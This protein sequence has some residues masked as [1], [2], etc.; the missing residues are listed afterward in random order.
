MGLLDTFLGNADQTQA[1]SLLGA[2]MMAG[3]TPQGLLA[4]S[5][6]M[7][8]AKDRATDREMKQMQMEEARMKMEQLRRAAA[9]EQGLSA[10]MPQFMN[11][12]RPAMGGTADVNAALPPEMQIGAQRP[13]PAQRPGFDIQGYTNAA[14]QQRLMN[15]LQA[16]EMQNKFA[17]ASQVN[18]LDVKD[19][20]PRSVAEFQRTG[21]Y[22]VLK[23]MDKLHFADTGGAIN[24]INPFTGVPVNSVP[25]TGNPFSD[26]LV[27]DGA[28]GFRPN[29]PLIGAKSQIARAGA[30]NM[31]MVN[32]QEGEESKAVG[33]FFGENYADV[34]KSG[35]N[36][37]SSMNRLD[38]LGQLLDGVD[39]GK[40]A[41]L[42]VEVSKAA[43][44]FGL[45]IDPKLAN[46]EAAVALSSEIALQLRNPSGGAGM[47]GAMSDA[48]RN[49]LNGMV[50]GIE[51]TPEGRKTIL[52][53]AKKM[54]QRDV[55]VAR[56]AREY[57][58]KR[59]T[60]NEGFYEELARFSE[61]NPLF[62]GGRSSG[63]GAN[64]DALVNKYAR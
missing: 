41:P 22:S 15:P 42:G 34:Q 46:K 55:Q 40:F 59:G 5:Q 57:R 16:L 23:R 33:K 19:F 35:F 6:Y 61:A 29:S 8:G 18:K 3:N 20:D 37:Q 7:G 28:G 62:A 49:F 17:P 32:K 50:P 47:P 51:K 64:I 4:A 56:M 48:D 58:Q 54:A 10:L 38:R 1:L 44:S 30:S 11:A 14:M 36:A 27:G 53:T 43:Q 12:G 9:N 25:K 2:N 24:A 60:I 52:E 39:T 13:M 45:N 31:T 21:D 63:G 26:L